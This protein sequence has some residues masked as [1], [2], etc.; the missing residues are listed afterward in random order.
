MAEKAKKK[1]DW[2]SSAPC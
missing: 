2:L 1:Y